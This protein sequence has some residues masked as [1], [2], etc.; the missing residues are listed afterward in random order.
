MNEKYFKTLFKTKIKDLDE[1]DWEQIHTLLSTHHTLES[2]LLVYALKYD[3]ELHLDQ[4]NRNLLYIFCH[5]TDY[6][7]YN[8][9]FSI[10]NQAV[11][12]KFKIAELLFKCI[13]RTYEKK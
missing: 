1:F 7:L 10:L 12:T 4:V 3:L 11:D 8:L 13:E 6:I 2:L 5:P 9:R